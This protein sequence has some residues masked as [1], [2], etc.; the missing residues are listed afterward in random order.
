MLTCPLQYTFG[1]EE[2]DCM[3]TLEL[4]G[5]ATLFIPRLPVCGEGGVYGDALRYV[6]KMATEALYAHARCC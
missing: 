1:A 2:A 6:E 5:K 4:S 3:G